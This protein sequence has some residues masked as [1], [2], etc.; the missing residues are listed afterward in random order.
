MRRFCLAPLCSVFRNEQTDQTGAHHHEA[1]RGPDNRK[2][3][4]G[5]DNK[6]KDA[7]NTHFL[8]TPIKGEKP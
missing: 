4:R 6:K 8:I 1:N 5:T 3:Q 7:A 2:A